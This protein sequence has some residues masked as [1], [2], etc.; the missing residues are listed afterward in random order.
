MDIVMTVGP[1]DAGQAAAEAALAGYD[2]LRRR[3]GGRLNQALNGVASVDG[4]F[5]RIT[6]A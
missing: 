1:D 4:A 6:S 3:W 5:A 2:T